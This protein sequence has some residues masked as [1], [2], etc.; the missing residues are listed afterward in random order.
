MPSDQPRRILVIADTQDR[1]DDAVHLL[2]EWAAAHGQ[3]IEVLA[4]HGLSGARRHLHEYI[5]LAVVNCLGRAASEAI[6]ILVGLRKEYRGPAVVM[7]DDA[8]VDTCS[9]G[10]RYAVDAHAPSPDALADCVAGLLLRR[11]PRGKLAVVFAGGGILGG[12][13][14]AGSLKALYDFGIRDFD[15]YIGLSAGA[16]VAGL[17]ANHVTPELMIEHPDLGWRDFY[18]VNSKDL[19]RQVALFGPHL[20]KALSQRVLDPESDW[21]FQLSGLFTASPLNGDR[22]RKRFREVLAQQGGT[23]DFAELRDRGRELYIMAVDLDTAERRVFGEGDDVHV[24]VA[25]AVTASATL[26]MFYRPVT[27]DGHDYVDGGLARSACIDT[28]ITNG[29]D[30]IVCVNPLV[31]Y[32]GGDPGFIKGLGLAGIAEQSVRALIHSRLHA[33]VEHYRHRNPHVTI[34][35]IEP[36]TDDLAMFHNP[37]R[38]SENMIRVAALEGFTSTKALL[39]ARAD[40][41]EHSFADHGRPLSRTRTLGI[42]DADAGL[43]N[44]P[45]A[46]VE[47]PDIQELA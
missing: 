43:E 34:L 2:S 15:M 6:A 28:A 5:N 45:D 41:I 7:N 29:A 37:L 35:L 13:N 19:I 8:A 14:E 10:R 18:H 44:I 12:F 39:E 16:W 9:W 4:V 32:T 23:N 36:D 42:T 3:D 11:R 31:P 27:I 33:T 17:A 21:L 26:P 24:P 47:Y 40:F 25:D 38:G 30:L 1:R 20:V 22:L 46:W